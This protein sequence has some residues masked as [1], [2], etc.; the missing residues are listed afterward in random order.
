MS[1]QPIFRQFSI[2]SN[3]PELVQ[4]FSTRVGGFSQ[5]PFDSLNLGLSTADDVHTVRRNRTLFFKA[6]GLSAEQMVFPQ[7]V[8]SANVQV[9]RQPGVIAECDALITAEKNLFLTVQTADCFPVFLYDPIKK[10][11]ALVHSGWRG[12]A[13]NIVGKTVLRMKNDFNCQAEDLRVGI[14]PGVQQMCYQVDQQTAKHFE[15]RFLKDDGPGHFRL[16]LQGAII[17]QLQQSG[18]PLKHIEVENVCTHCA[19]ETYFSYRRDGQNS[20]RMMGVIGIVT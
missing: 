15:P 16:D 20:G 10:V 17:H 14:G 6:L 9:V 12:T 1:V 11:V 8:H 18:V 4:A 5:P 3:F 7:Q 13:Q 19:Q 2:F